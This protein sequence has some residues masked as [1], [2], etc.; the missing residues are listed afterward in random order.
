MIHKVILPKLGQTMVGGQ[1]ETWHKAEGDAIALGDVLFEMTTDKATQEVEAMAAGTLLKVFSAPGDEVAVNEI[2]ALIAIAG[3]S[4]VAIPAEFE[5]Y[6]PKSPAEVAPETGA[7]Q[8]ATGTATPPKQ[9]V[10]APAVAAQPKTAVAQTPQAVSDHVAPTMPAPFDFPNIP[11]NGRVFASPRAKRLARELKVPH[12]IL[13]GSGPA[14]RI[15]EADVR[16]YVD[17]VVNGRTVTPAAWTRAQQRSVDLRF[18]EGGGLGGRVERADVENARPSHAHGGHERIELTS[19]RR[20]IAERM[21]YSNAAIPQYQLTSWVNMEAAQALRAAAKTDGR[22]F[23]ITDLILA[24]CARGIIGVPQ[25]GDLFSGD[26]IIRRHQIHIGLAVALEPPGSG[27]IAPVIRDVDRL[28]L[29]DVALQRQELVKRARAGRLKPDEYSGGIFTV[30]NLGGFA[31]DSFA[32]VVQPGEAGIM[33]VGAIAPRP[34]VEDDA[35]CIRHT[36]SLTLSA[37]HRVVD[38]ADG[39]RFLQLVKDALEAPG[40]LDG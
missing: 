2:V 24:A 31:V 14:G 26:H 12:H 13:N 21:T 18:V 19:M 15:V 27:L 5:N 39:A 34:V 8:P 40:A 9:A 7:S 35:L 4:E 29:D 23:T 33:A 10:T 16:A 36:M 20:A 25:M 11:P 6:R 1:I 28:K 32:A 37:D 3:E 22:P 38:G 17:A 30:S